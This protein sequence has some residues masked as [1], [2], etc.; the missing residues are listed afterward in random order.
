MIDSG[1]LT[2]IARPYAAAAFEYALAKKALPAWEM[3]L[4]S[5]ASITRD[6]S[7]KKLLVSPKAAKKA[8]G[9]LYCDLLAPQL[10]TEKTNFV[11][12]L[13]ENSRLIA[14]PEI[15][16]LFAIA[17]AE[18]EKKLT[19]T[20]SSADELSDAYKQKLVGA[21]TKRL[22]REVELQCDVDTNLL[23]GVIVRA[24]DTVIDGSIRGKL[25]RLNEFI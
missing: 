12:L 18:A 14:L 13:A 4:Q 6:P 24:G 16:A 15:A 10:D 21:L 22:D 3:L 2:T 17:R 25:L 1:K 20:V 7:I 8:L 5:A 11:R 23:G 9:D 19:V